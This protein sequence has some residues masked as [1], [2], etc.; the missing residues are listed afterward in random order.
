MS[1]NAINASAAVNFLNIRIRDGANEAYFTLKR[2][3][4]LGKIFDAWCKY[5][6]KSRPDFAFFYD[7][8]RLQPTDTPE[9][10][11]LHRLFGLL[12]I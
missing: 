6:D 8:A 5:Q 2:D 3:I 7:G 10:V 4:A 1:H 9:S 12:G 11:S